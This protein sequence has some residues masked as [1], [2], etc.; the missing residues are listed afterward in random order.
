MRTR[1]G[2]R[3]G[4]HVPLAAACLVLLLGMPAMGITYT[5][6]GGGAPSVDWSTAANWDAAGVPTSASSTTVVFGGNTNMGTS[7][8]RLDQD[9]ATPLMLNRLVSENVASGDVDVYLGGGQLQFVADGATQPTIHA[10]RD[11]F[12]H[13]GNA[14]D[15]P[16]GTLTV[17]N[18]TWNINL[19][20]PIT[21]SGAIVFNTG[22]GGGGLNLEN[23]ANSYSGGTTYIHAGGPNASWRKF[24]VTNSG[25]LGTGDV[26][27]IGGNLNPHNP[28]TNNHPGGLIFLNAG[29]THANDFELQ[30]DSP[31]F[32]GEPGV[33]GHAGYTV[34]LTGN[35]DLN[36]YVLYLRGR[37]TGTISGTISST[38]GP[39]G[40]L[41]MDPATW[42]LTSRN[43]YAGDTTVNAGKLV[44]AA[45]NA[46]AS[47]IGTGKLI[48]NSGATVDSGV[49]G[50]GWTFQNPV[51][52]YGGTLNQLSADSHMNTITMQAGTLGGAGEFRLHRDVTVLASATA[53]TI[54][55]ANLGIWESMT[56]DVADGGAPIDLDV[57]SRLTGGGT[58]TK[59]GPGTM[60]IHGSN[61]SFNGSVV[62]DGG[63]L[64]F[65]GGANSHPIGYSSARTITIGPGA[66][67]TAAQE[68]HNPFGTN[69]EPP[70]VI[71]NGGTM[72]TARYQHMRDIDMTGG[73]IQPT[74]TEASGLDMKNSPTIHVF[75]SG[76]T[77]T[78]ASKMTFNS[79][80]VTFDVEDGAAAN[81]L[82][83]SGVIVGSQGLI[84]TGTG[85]ML[86]SNRGNSYTGG[87]IVEAGTLT[88]NGPNSGVSL[89]G[90]G[91]LTINSS[92]QVDAYV[93]AFGWTYQN[94][95]HINGGTLRSIGADSHLNTVT[96]TG[97]LLTGQEFRP[98][99]IFTINAS[100]DTAVIDVNTLNLF[101]T[102]TFDVADGAAD[103]DLR[104]DSRIV[105][106]NELI[107]AG[108]GTMV[109]TNTANSYSR[110][111]IDA[112]VLQ[113]GA[114]GVLPDN[115]LHNNWG[116]GG[117]LDLNGHDE[118]INRLGG[119]PDIINT[120]AGTPTLTIGINNGNG[121]NYGG[122]ISGDL[123]I[124]KAGTGWQQLS[125]NNTYSGGTIVD[126]G[127]LRLAGPNDPTS[128]VGLGDLVINPNGTVR[129]LSHNVLGHTAKANI[130]NV[131]INGGTLIPYQYLHV[132]DID[133]TGG[134]IEAGPAGGA[135][136]QTHASTF[137]GN[138]AAGTAF[139]RARIQAAMGD[140]AFDIADGAAEPDMHVTAQIY[141]GNGFS[142]TGAGTLLL[143]GSNTY[144]GATAVNAGTLLLDGTH[145]GGG[146]YTVGDG[147]TLGGAGSTSSHVTVQQ[148]HRAGFDGHQ[149]LDQPLDIQSADQAYAAADRT[150]VDTPC[151]KGRSN[152]LKN[153]KA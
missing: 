89:I 48:I 9:I 78:I 120:G 17:T 102:V 65:N 38:G 146:A 127:E 22:S 152:R 16:T 105:G 63:T 114:S 80:A 126:A 74:G 106:G 20:G 28:A 92:G 68:T 91:P 110:T 137:T 98:H 82:V 61:S 151:L 6:D 144:S 73:I 107:K 119:N 37:G 44:L 97:G 12:L 50:F 145:T 54:N 128:S 79:G 21:G 141:G 34:D 29:R 117:T 42:T 153:E 121:W 132:A 77:A 133:M 118:A 27:L 86:L 32:I 10:D 43:T 83:V 148:G 101:N 26:T 4:L 3:A 51:E 70:K 11:R 19:Q 33:A 24:R 67:L 35:I 104:I 134:V 96:M 2:M 90:T 140:I 84:K 71:I 122:Q 76:S 40:L 112:G 75:A 52:L 123:A 150:H 66:T 31:I 94:A 129:A 60:G 131:V 149:L 88:L 143:S 30:A 58:L 109:V 125:G 8:A 18:R 64:L 138:A 130:P 23:G 7:G 46:A 15:I 13:V 147:A 53:S 14:I 25:A 108:P 113:L 1:D 49:N 103:P 93:N 99:A 85:T 45:P 57:A 69:A 87:T 136:L 59:D 55:T 135:G 5:W 81:D 95:I 100:P 47:T 139:I 39:G 142:K 116:G 115:D 111:K 41:K 62:V 56:F 124:R 72:N 36:N